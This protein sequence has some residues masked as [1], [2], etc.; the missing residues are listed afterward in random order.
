MNNSNDMQMDLTPDFDGRLGDVQK[1]AKAEGIPIIPNDTARFLDALLA[2]HKPFRALEIGCAVGFSA[3]LIC[4]RLRPGGTLV[5]I[6]RYD[7]MITQARQNFEFLG[8]NDRVKLIEGDA[9]EIL[10]L[11][12]GKFDFIFIDAAKGQYPVFL[13]EAVRLLDVGGILVADD[14]FQNGGL[15]VSRL[16]VKRRQ[17]TTH[18]RM[19]LFLRQIT[20]TDGLVTSIL[21]IGDGLSFT[22]KTKDDIVLEDCHEE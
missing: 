12:N 3:G 14:I 16:A 19:R 2:V 5:T 8:I 6:D 1:R 7:Y 10:P 21:P 22:V 18:T 17:R 4:Q 11:L 20:N 15:S 13:K 9:A